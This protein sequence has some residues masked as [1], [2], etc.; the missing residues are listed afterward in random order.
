MFLVVGAVAFLLSLPS[1]PTLLRVL[2]YLYSAWW[3]EHRNFLSYA[4][5]SRY[6][7]RWVG[8]RRPLCV[9]ESE[10]PP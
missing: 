9:S 6:E 10:V 8:G 2:K 3:R 7:P 4:I 5:K 1:F